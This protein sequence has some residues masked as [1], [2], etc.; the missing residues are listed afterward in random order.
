MELTVHN[1]NEGTGPLVSPYA[2]VKI[3]YTGKLSNGT[4]FVN[5]SVQEF[6]LSLKDV[7]PGLYKGI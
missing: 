2:K 1:L 5:K 7:I 6:D 4:V 3:Q